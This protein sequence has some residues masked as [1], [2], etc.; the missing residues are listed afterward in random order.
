VP[1]E[2][3]VADMEGSASYDVSFN[4]LLLEDD[5]GLPFRVEP[6]NV[7]IRVVVSLEADTVFSSASCDAL[8]LEPPGAFAIRDNDGVIA[9]QRNFIYADG[10]G[11]L[12]SE[13]VPGGGISGDWA[14]RLE[15]IAEGGRTSDA[16]TTPDASAPDTGMTLTDATT[17]AATPPMPEEGGC[18]CRTATRK[19]SEST[20][21]A[22]LFV[23][24]SVWFFRRTLY[25]QP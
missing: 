24:A 3:S 12:W 1:V 14:L 18:G 16:G 17:D 19:P 2:R 23:I 4:R 21:A 9:N 6:P 5:A 8:G 11:W 13:D 22:V 25:Q 7:Y 20:G 15:V 10:L